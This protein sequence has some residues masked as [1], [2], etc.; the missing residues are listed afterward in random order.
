[1][2]NILV[3]IELAGDR[4]AGAS[5]ETLGE[6]R[7]I[8]SF[9]GATLYAVLP[10]VSP[11]A[12]GE[13]DIIAVLSRHGADKV[14]LTAAPELTGPFLHVPTGQALAAACEQFPPALVLCAATPAGRD[15]A[16]RLAARLG[17]AFVPEPSVEYGPRGDLVLSRTVYCGAFRRRLAADDVERPVVATLTQGSYRPAAGN[18]EAEVVVVTP[19]NALAAPL[20]ELDRKDDPGAKLDGARVVVTAGA[21]VSREVYPLVQ[22][23][24]R[25]LGGEVGVTRAAVE[26]GLDG[27]ERQIGV[28]GRSISPRL[29]IAC[30]AAGSPG[31]LA[32]VSADAHIVAINR[33]PTAPIF[34]VAAYGIVGDLAEVIP[35]ILREL[36][37]AVPRAAPEATT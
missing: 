11:P 24:A 17:A 12:W 31:H 30:G 16:P 5:L 2:A 19:P 6:A 34:R 1:V 18:D 28:G 35:E 21:G 4:P 29:Y 10:C 22:A 7:R 37:S 15:I 27:P 26:G 23:L 36:D 32:A 20:F 14:V 9:L 13:D 25:A 3:Y 33:D 8:A